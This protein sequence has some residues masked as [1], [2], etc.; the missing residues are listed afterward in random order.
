MKKFLALVGIVSVLFSFVA[1]SSHE[2]EIC[3]KD[4]DNKVEFM[5]QEGYFCDD[6]MGK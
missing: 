5:G 1:C 4:A 3:G 6:C 2:C